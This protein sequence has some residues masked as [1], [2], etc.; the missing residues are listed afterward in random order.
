MG[1]EMRIHGPV[2]FG[3]RI[4][5]RFTQAHPH[6]RIGRIPG[7]PGLFGTLI[8]MGGADFTR[9]EGG[10]PTPPLRRGGV[11]FTSGGGVGMAYLSTVHFELG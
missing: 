3:V 1:T 9:R 7:G 10:L 5:P 2:A 11:T 8:R 6:R 4:A